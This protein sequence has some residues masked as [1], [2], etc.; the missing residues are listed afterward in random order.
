MCRKERRCHI[1]RWQER[2][3]TT[4]ILP[5]LFELN[6]SGK[7]SNFWS[8]FAG[9]SDRVVVSNQSSMPWAAKR[10]DWVSSL[11]RKM[12]CPRIKNF[13]RN[14]TILVKKVSRELKVVQT[15]LRKQPVLILSV[16]PLY[17]IV[18]PMMLKLV[19]NKKL[20][21]AHFYSKRH[22]LRRRTIL[23]DLFSLWQHT[24]KPIFSIHGA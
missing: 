13:P 17:V 8:V 11:F 23:V 2:T 4:S 22:H 16:L 15:V 14:Q 24:T 19:F 21:W 18:S 9:L 6:P 3:N 10:L 1:A 20:L 5:F 7:I 12:H